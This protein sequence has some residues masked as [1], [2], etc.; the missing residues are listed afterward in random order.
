MGLSLPPSAL[1]LPFVVVAA[2]LFCG[3]SSRGRGG[4]CAEGRRRK[5]AI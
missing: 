3:P 4:V 5:T 1:V 2:A